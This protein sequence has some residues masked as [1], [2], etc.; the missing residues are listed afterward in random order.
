MNTPGSSGPRSPSS[1][2]PAPQAG[3]ATAQKILAAYKIPIYGAGASPA[4]M[5]VVADGLRHYSTQNLQG[6]SRIVIHSRSGGSLD[7][8]WSSDGQGAEVELIAHV[9]RSQ[10]VTLHTVTH[11]L[12]HHWSLFSDEQGGKVFD[13]ALGNNA[14]AYVS[15]Y[16]HNE[17]SDK[18]AEAVAYMLIGYDKAEQPPLRAWN[19]SPQAFEVLN[20]RIVA[21]RP[22][23]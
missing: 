4:V 9:N 15:E 21:Q 19:P 18:I 22:R 8:Q 17:W 3:S 23:F 6:L 5:D 10:P 20:Q 2:L 16:A 11:E 1:L 7:G 12:G 13:Q 14:A